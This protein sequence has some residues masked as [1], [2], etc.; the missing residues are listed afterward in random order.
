MNILKAILGIC[1]TKPPVDGGCWNCSG[2]R[3]EIDPSRAPEL[4]KPGGAIRL[5]GQGLSERVLVLHGTDGK[6]HAF[7][8]RCQH[9]GRRIG[10]RDGGR[11][12]NVI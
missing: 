2:G 3:I 10:L 5:E 7:Q 8:N 12:E 4:S 9:M 6:F 1:E 11:P